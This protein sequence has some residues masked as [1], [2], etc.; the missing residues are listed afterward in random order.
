M[1]GMVV[2]FDGPSHKQ[3][4]SVL[5]PHHDEVLGSD[6]LLGHILEMV[7]SRNLLVAVDVNHHW[8]CLIR[9]CKYMWEDTSLEATTT[10]LEGLRALYHSRVVGMTSLDLSRCRKLS[11]IFFTS[12]SAEIPT[13]NL[14]SLN[15]SH[16]S[17]LDV[18]SLF[19]Q[20]RGVVSLQSLNLDWCHNVTNNTVDAICAQ[21]QAQA[22]PT[23]LTNL[24]MRGCPV[25][26][27]GLAKL[28]QYVILPLFAPGLNCPTVKAALSCPFIL[29]HFRFPCALVVSGVLRVSRS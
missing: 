17:K 12:F 9:N 8:R 7:P 27:A 16:C 29:T 20:W 18:D 26:N 14:L 2:K 3:P 4:A 15:V 25:G 24:S 19:T 21:A 28:C 11:N 23:A 1:S 5:S 6:D 22:R 10:D 13:R